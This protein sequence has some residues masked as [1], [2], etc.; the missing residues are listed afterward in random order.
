MARRTNSRRRAR[1]NPLKT[2][3]KVLIGVGAAGVLAGVLYLVTR[4]KGVSGTANV[5]APQQPSGQVPLSEPGPGVTVPG[6][7]APMPVMP[8]PDAGD[9][10]LPPEVRRAARLRA[11]PPKQWGTPGD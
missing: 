5:A 9:V 10:N 8:R 4:K 3:D 6:A 1:E 2:R 7:F 11:E